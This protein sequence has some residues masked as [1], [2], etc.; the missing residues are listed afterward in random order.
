MNNLCEA[1]VYL[2][3]LRFSSAKQAA[4]FVQRFNIGSVSAFD[5]A[6]DATVSGTAVCMWFNRD[7]E[8]KQ[9]R[10]PSNY[11]SDAQYCLAEKLRNVQRSNE[12]T[13]SGVCPLA[14]RMRRK[15]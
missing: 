6:T 7:G 11:V 12:V 3:A 8:R 4:T 14:S 15:K 2:D 9:T 1:E 5:V 10:P 13:F